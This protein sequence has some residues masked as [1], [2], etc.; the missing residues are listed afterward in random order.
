[1][2][3]LKMK[4][5]KHPPWLTQ[6]MESSG[7]KSIRTL[8][9]CCAG[10]QSDHS[11]ERQVCA[12]VWRAHSFIPPVRKGDLGM[13]LPARAKSDHH[14]VVLRYSPRAR[15]LTWWTGRAVKEQIDKR[16]IHMRLSMHESTRGGSLRASSKDMCCKFALEFEE[17]KGTALQPTRMTLDRETTVVMADS[18]SPHKLLKYGSPI[19]MWTTT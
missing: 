2:F 16:C 19:F 11:P 15:Q 18:S 1:M 12:K 17:R 10:G 8:R 13:K 3:T 4:A 6:I 9:F 14:Y 7:V 5:D